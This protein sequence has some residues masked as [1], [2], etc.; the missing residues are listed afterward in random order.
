VVADIMRAGPGLG[1]SR[2]ASDYNQ[3]VKAAGTATTAPWCWRPDS[4]QEMADLTLWPS[5]SPTSTE[6]RVCWRMDTPGR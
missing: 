6:T 1:T 4:V 5:I 3:I 2:R